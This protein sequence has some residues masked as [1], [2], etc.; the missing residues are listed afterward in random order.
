[1]VDY[2][3]A[4]LD[5][6]MTEAR[7]LVPSDKADALEADIKSKTNFP[8]VL[9]RFLM[10]FVDAMESKDLEKYADMPK[11]VVDGNM[12]RKPAASNPWSAAG[13]NATEQSR[14]VKRIGETKAAAIA[15]AAGCKLGST[16]PNP[17][18]N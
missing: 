12:P 18:Y 15:D 3:Q 8:N 10:R 9:G 14:L 2:T 16:K 7:S 4:Q 1:M 13:W 5:D 17:A 11:V 6:L